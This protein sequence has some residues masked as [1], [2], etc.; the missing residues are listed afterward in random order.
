MDKLMKQW[1]TQKELEIEMSKIFISNQKFV[2]N[3]KFEYEEKLSYSEEPKVIKEFYSN[4]NLALQLESTGAHVNVIKQ[5]YEN[6]KLMARSS[7]SHEYKDGAFEFHFE[8]GSFLK[9]HFMLNI[10]DKYFE[11]YYDNGNLKEKIIF[12]ISENHDGIGESY[13]ENGNLIGHWI[14]EKRIF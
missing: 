1:D 4:G 11:N 13:D 14:N 9:Y 8:N 10:L 12:D 3:L 6:G 2:K 7:F 5:Y